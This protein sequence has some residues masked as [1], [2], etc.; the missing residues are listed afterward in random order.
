VDDLREGIVHSL[1]GVPLRTVLF[2]DIPFELT[3]LLLG[4]A[5]FLGRRSEIQ[6]VHGDDICPG[7][8]VGVAYEGIELAPG[9]GQS[10]LDGVEPLLL[11]FV[12]DVSA[13][14][15]QAFSLGTRA[16]I[17]RYARYWCEAVR[18]EAAILPTRKVERTTLVLGCTS[19]LSQ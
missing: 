12:V 8:Q 18:Y 17:G 4:P 3:P 5:E 13:S 14:S 9:L 15:S 7:P 2:R 19:A 10:R 6:E 11:L 1:S 16:L